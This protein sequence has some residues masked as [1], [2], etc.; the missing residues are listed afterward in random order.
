MYAKDNVGY[1]ERYRF[2]NLYGRYYGNK[3]EYYYT[4]SDNTLKFF[5]ENKK[6]K[7]IYNGDPIQLSEFGNKEFIFKE[8]TTERR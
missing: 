3:Y 5:I 7:E 1:D 6:N 4:N 2:L 8:H